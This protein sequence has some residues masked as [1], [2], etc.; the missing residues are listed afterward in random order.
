MRAKSLATNIFMFRVHKLG[1][2]NLTLT[3][4]GMREEYKAEGFPGANMLKGLSSV[5]G[6]LTMYFTIRQNS[7]KIIANKVDLSIYF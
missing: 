6:L 3:V 7:I 2:S 1:I 4:I 5:Q